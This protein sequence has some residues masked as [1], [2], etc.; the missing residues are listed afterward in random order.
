MQEDLYL[1]TLMSFVTCAVLVLLAGTE[2]LQNEVDLMQKYAHTE[3]EDK[4]LPGLST[5]GVTGSS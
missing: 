3:Y 1:A 4:L 2:I 5:W